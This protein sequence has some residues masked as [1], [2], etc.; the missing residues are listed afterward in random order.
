M[1]PIL[2]STVDALAGSVEYEVIASVSLGETLV[3]RLPIARGATLVE[4]WQSQTVS[5][6]L[7]LPIV[8]SVGTL[9][10][11]RITSPL[12]PF[13][14]R[15]KITQ[16]VK[17]AGLVIDQVPL[18]EFLIIDPDPG[19]E[20]W[21]RYREGAWVSMGA[22]LDV[23]AVDLLELVSAAPL[24]QDVAPSGTTLSDSA[25]LLDGILPIGAWQAKRTSP[26]GTTWTDERVDGLASLA[27][28]EGCVPAVSRVGAYLPRS[29]TIKATPDWILTGGP[30]GVLGAVRRS[31]AAAGIVQAVLITGETGD[32]NDQRPT[33]GVAYITRG[34]LR[35]GGP[36]G[37]RAL[38]EHNPLARTDGIAT[39]MAETR[40]ANLLAKLSVTVTV[41][42]ANHPGLE[43][44]DTVTL[45][46]PTGPLTGLATRIE[47]P[48]DGRSDMEV[49]VSIPWEQVWDE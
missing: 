35:Y 31:A 36:F 39:E 15:L 37:R 23:K 25:K 30:S 18:G 13:G 22:Q 4:E 46:L 7:S 38:K 5:S 26:S 47:R 41:T 40:L 2:Q 1:W 28:L 11:E 12:A 9:L 14:Q 48:L 24:L 34:P 27:A 42:C 33:R 49:T 44:L 16:L 17:V 10:T 43:V 29:S 21:H 3:E 8:D 32:E 45:S 20:R 6:T 19:E